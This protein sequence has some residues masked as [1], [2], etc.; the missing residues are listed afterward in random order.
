VIII[1]GKVLFVAGYDDIGMYSDGC[2]EIDRIIGVR[3]VD[4][5]RIRFYFN[6][7]FLVSL[8]YRLQLTSAY[9]CIASDAGIERLREI[10]GGSDGKSTTHVDR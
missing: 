2:L 5:V 9:D 4:G 6:G 7:D 1:R 3:K 10:P 8:L